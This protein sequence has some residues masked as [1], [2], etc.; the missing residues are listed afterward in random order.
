MKRPSYLR[1]SVAIGLFC[2]AADQLTKY[3]ALVHVPSG[4][5]RGSGFFSLRLVHNAGAAFSFASSAT[6]A[7]T[8][9]ALVVV[10]VLPALVTRTDSRA[11]ACGL[12]LI[13]GGAAG[14]LVDRLLRSPGFGRGEVVDFIGWGNWF[15]GNVAD[16]ALGLGIGLVVVL[17]FCHIDFASETVS[18]GNEGRR[19]ATAE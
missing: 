5:V 1:G 13:W 8:A 12:G 7:I 17:S 2:L 3:L 10:L 16:I 6:Y 18:E 14:N 9:L 15:T 4:E 11:W 19:A